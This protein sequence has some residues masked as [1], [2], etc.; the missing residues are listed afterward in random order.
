MYL[1]HVYERSLPPVP[2][3]VSIYLRVHVK[4]WGG[5]FNVNHHSPSYH[6]SSSSSSSTSHEEFTHLSLPPSQTQGK[7]I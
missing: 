5:F 1:L 4:V 3:Y 7:T 6:N 2:N